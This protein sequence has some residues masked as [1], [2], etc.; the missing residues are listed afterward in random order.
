VQTGQNAVIVGFIINGGGSKSLLLRALGPTLGQSPFNVP[1][2]LANPTLE[3][4]DSSGNLI[5]SNDNWGDASNKQAIMNTGKAPPN[6]LESAILTSLTPG[7]YTAIAR[8]VN[9]GTCNALVEAY[10]LDDNTSASNLANISTR[11]FVQTGNNVMIAGV[12]VQ[13]IDNENVIVRGLGP[14]L[15]QFGV[16]SVLADP[17]LELRDVNGN[18]VA[19]ND[20]WKDT[21]QTEIETTGLA[22][23]NDKES[24]ISA[25]LSSANYTAILR[26]KN[27]TTGNALVEVYALH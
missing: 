25:T 4:H 9:S 6:A 18:L 21:Q 15:S 3:L 26:G 17:M 20:N 1:N 5:I 7:S 12:I 14:T 22:P 11:S 27:N 10:N 8:G 16:P 19:S 13:G 23:P 24:A 2:V